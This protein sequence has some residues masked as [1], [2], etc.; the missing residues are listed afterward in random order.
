[1]TREIKFRAWDKENKK[2]VFFEIPGMYVEDY[3]WQ[4]YEN[5]G[6]SIGLKDWTGR[7]IYEGDLVCILYPKSDYEIKRLKT[8]HKIEVIEHKGRKYVR[9][10]GQAILIKW[11]DRDVRWV[12]G[13]R[14]KKK[15]EYGY[16]GMTGGRLSLRGKTYF[17]IGNIY[18]NPELLHEEI[19]S[20]Q[21][22]GQK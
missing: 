21:V 6:Q 19:A 4:Y 11:S 9:F 17:V 1:M 5:W 3:E 18:E 16:F 20:I 14:R 22:R 8:G 10:L 15:T 7:N 12:L 13:E 2:W